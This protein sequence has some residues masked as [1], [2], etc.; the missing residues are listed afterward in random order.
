M[1]KTKRRS[2][3]IAHKPKSHPSGFVPQNASA[4]SNGFVP[5]T[6]EPPRDRSPNAS[7]DPGSSTAPAPPY[8]EKAAESVRS[9][10][11]ENPQ[12]ITA[13]ASEDRGDLANT[14]PEAAPGVVPQNP[15]TT[16]DTTR[17]SFAN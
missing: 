8:T 1:A 12:S 16:E 7:P 6:R 17:S 9:V 13:T 4:P 11:F 5:Q 2:R 10:R 15:T 14:N 3:N